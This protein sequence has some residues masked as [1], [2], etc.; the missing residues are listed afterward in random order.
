MLWTPIPNKMKTF[1]IALVIGS[2]LTLFGANRTQ[3]SEDRE[4]VFLSIENY[5]KDN[6]DH[7]QILSHTYSEERGG[8]YVFTC[9][10]T[11]L[12]KPKGDWSVYIS[13]ELVGNGEAI[14]ALFI[15]G[16][17]DYYLWVDRCIKMYEAGYKKAVGAK[18]H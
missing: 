18:H 5:V 13:N 6:A 9:E 7:W 12:D 8:T 17:V 3:A 15:Q 1:I 14:Q 16:A 11:D 10:C 4:D 2:A